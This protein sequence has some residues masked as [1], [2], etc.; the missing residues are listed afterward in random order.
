MHTGQSSGISN[1]AAPPR[2]VP[3]IPRCTLQRGS[4]ACALDLQTCPSCVPLHPCRSPSYRV[5]CWALRGTRQ[6]PTGAK[7]SRCRSGSFTRD[8][9]NATGRTRRTGRMRR[10]GT[11]S[12]FRTAAVSYGLPSTASGA[13]LRAPHPRDLQLENHLLDWDGSQRMCCQRYCAALTVQ[14][15]AA[16]A[17]WTLLTAWTLTAPLSQQIQ[18]QTPA[19]GGSQLC[20]NQTFGR[21]AGRW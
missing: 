14:C 2:Q 7:C 10:G 6:S 1:P 12:S 15:S 3:S 18:A 9:G 8:C 20:S 4:Q 19:H 13:C 16:V 11:C 17:A 21:I 5:R